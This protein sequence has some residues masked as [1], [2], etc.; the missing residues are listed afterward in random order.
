MSLEADTEKPA[1][2]ET[3]IFEDAVDQAVYV[4]VDRN[5]PDLPSEAA[6]VSSNGLNEEKD[7][8]LPALD[9]NSR[10][11][12]FKMVRKLL[13]DAKSMRSFS[14]TASTIAPSVITD[15]VKRGLTEQEKRDQKQKAVPKGEASAVRRMRKDNAGIVREYAGWDF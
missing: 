1:P 14:T 12:R 7:D 2:E 10:E 13:D 9:P 3:D 8:E 4:E 5:S 11:Y 15:R 6:S